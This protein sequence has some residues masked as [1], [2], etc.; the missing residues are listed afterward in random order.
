MNAAVE[1]TK[2]HRDSGLDQEE[3]H[4]Q[5]DRMEG[6]SRSSHKY[7]LL[8]V[9][10]GLLT[11]AMVVMAAFLTSIKPK[12]TEDA[13]S[14]LKPDVSPTV[15][16][17]VAPSKLTGS[18]PSF[19]QLHMHRDSWEHLDSCDSCFLV[20]HNDSIHCKK[21]GLYFIYSQVTFS[22]LTV[23]PPPRSVILIRNARPGRRLKKLVEGSFSHK[24]EGSVWVAKIVKLSEG[25]SFSIN[26]TGDFLRQSTFWGAFQLH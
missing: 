17:L 1:K 7:L 2:S 9:W 19:I 24:Q 13:V 22:E 14:T 20:L 5:S 11:V 15:N 16:T 4:E 26:I 10:C 12:S 21:D 8:Q 6:Q 25:D 18:S 23:S 3:R